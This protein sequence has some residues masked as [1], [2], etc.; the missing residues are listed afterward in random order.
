VRRLWAAPLF[1]HR[2]LTSPVAGDPD[3][4]WPTFVEHGCDL[5]CRV[6][7]RCVHFRCVHFRCVHF[8]CVQW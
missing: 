2:F 6:H 7:F 4:L 3:K 1:P 5:L 8:R